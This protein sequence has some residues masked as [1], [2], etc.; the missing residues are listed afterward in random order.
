[1]DIT[2]RERLMLVGKKERIQAVTA[3]LLD[4]YKDKQH[5][6]QNG[7][8]IAKKLNEI[9]SLLSVLASYAK[10]DRDLSAF[11][12]FYA[13]ILYLGDHLGWE[14]SDFQVQIFCAA[15]NSVQFKFHK[16]RIDVF[17]DKIFN[18]LN[19]NFFKL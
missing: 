8:E 10:P 7:T 5:I 12:R 14:F 13:Q 1:M 9:V 19:L 11:T 15:A 4:I 16:D 2:D 17:I 6:S 18:E 3:E